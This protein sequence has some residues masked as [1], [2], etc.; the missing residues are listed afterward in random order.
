M[1]DVK[2]LIEQIGGR[3][4]LN[5]LASGLYDPGEKSKEKLALLSNALLEVLD[6]KPI[7]T[8]SISPDMYSIPRRNIATV[9]M[10]P[11]LV[12]SEMRD[13][14]NLYTK[15]PAASVP[16]EW[17]KCSDRMPEVGQDVIGWNGFAIRQVRYRINTYARTEKGRLPRFESG[18][19]IWHGV[20]HWTP[21]PAAPGAE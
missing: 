16:D 1:S 20:T 15:P 11:D 3:V 10:R 13:G 8:V 6:A 9:N 19:G 21:L 7:G 4:I 5:G 14:D 18:N 12:M 2:K 17:I